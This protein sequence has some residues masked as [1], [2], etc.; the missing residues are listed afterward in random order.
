MKKTLTLFKIKW[1]YQKVLS[2]DFIK[3]KNIYKEAENKKSNFI[4][5]E[6]FCLFNDSSLLFLSKLI[7]L[8]KLFMF[9]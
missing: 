3:K 2:K 7:D 5:T 8:F 9:I 1:L 4:K 6:L